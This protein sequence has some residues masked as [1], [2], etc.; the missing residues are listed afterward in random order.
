MTVRQR[1]TRREIRS[2]RQ[3]PPPSRRRRRAVPPGAQDPDVA[4]LLPLQAELVLD[5]R[6]VRVLLV[7]RHREEVVGVQ[8]GRDLREGRTR[9]VGGRRAVRRSGIGRSGQVRRDGPRRVRR[10]QRV[11]AVRKGCQCAVEE[12]EVSERAP[13]RDG[14]TAEEGEEGRAGG[15]HEFEGG[16]AGHLLEASVLERGRGV[17]TNES[18]RGWRRRRMQ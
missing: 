4:A 15:G 3:L 2:V 11:R 17:G 13:R 8:R 7:V 18:E 1:P 16:K 9:R 12:D 10:L 6:R 5:G 14:T